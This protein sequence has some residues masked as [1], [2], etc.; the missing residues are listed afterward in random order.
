MAQK[1]R[2]F[3]MFQL[4][5]LILTFISL[6]ASGCGRLQKHSHPTEARAIP[7]KIETLAPKAPQNASEHLAT[8]PV[9][10]V[11]FDG[12]RSDYAEKFNLPNF[13][14]LK[15]MGLSSKGLVPVNPSNTFPNHY[16]IVTGLYPEHHLLINNDMYDPTTKKRYQ[17][18]DREQVQ[19]GSWYGG[20]PLWNLARAQNMVSASFFWVGSDANIQ[21]TY[22][23]YYRIYDTSIPNNQRIEQVLTWLR[24]PEKERPRFLT[25]YFSHVDSVG[26]E[27]GPDSDENKNAALEADQLLGNILAGLEALKKENIDTN[28]IVLSDHGM[29]NITKTI[30]LPKEI[31]EDPNILINGRGSVV[32]LSLGPDLNAQQ[33]KEKLAQMELSLSNRPKPWP[34]QFYRPGINTPGH[35]HINHPRAG[36][37][38]VVAKPG[39]YL[40][41]KDNKRTGGT[42]GY[43]TKE[44]KEMNAIFLA[45]G[46]NILPGRMS[47]FENIH[48]YPFITQLLKLKLPAMMDGKESVLK[49]YIER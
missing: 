6:L 14:K 19:D 48:V 9:L 7:N 27:F 17:I 33:A 2:G 5:I 35:W 21:G 20:T 38:M 30:I 45:K 26:H 3:S 4:P 43:D 1:R 34:Y 42:H 23:H 18:K 31:S 12:F 41:V 16:S 46:P 22:P 11:S 24:F 10:L 49:K 39:H 28:L 36:Q 44:T 25:L 40:D 47:E 32:F 13:L 15:K 29:T 37:L 8:N